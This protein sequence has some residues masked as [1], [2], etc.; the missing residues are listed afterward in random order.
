MLC[1]I[2]WFFCNP[3]PSSEMVL[4]HSFSTVLQVVVEYATQC[5]QCTQYTQY[6]P[7]SICKICNIPK[8]RSVKYAIYV[9]CAKRFIQTVVD[10][11]NVILRML[12]V[13]TRRWV[14]QNGWVLWYVFLYGNRLCFV[15]VQTAFTVSV[16]LFFALKSFREKLLA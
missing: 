9:I 5:M 12:A 16:V 6:E 15:H 13:P 2:D 10:L 11:Q 8:W 7:K 14:M 3:I 1:L 4:C